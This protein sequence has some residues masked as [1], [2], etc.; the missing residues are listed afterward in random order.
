MRAGRNSCGNVRARKRRRQSSRSN[1]RQAMRRSSRPIRISRLIEQFTSPPIL[2][3][4]M[5]VIET[6][7]PAVKILVPAKHG[8][9]RGFFSE[10]YSRQKLKDAGID[11]DFVQDNQ[12]LSVEKG[13]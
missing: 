7:I 8:D 13:V 5:Q 2:L 12:S 3:Q 1:R 11:I 6:Q 9:H 10:T 4:A